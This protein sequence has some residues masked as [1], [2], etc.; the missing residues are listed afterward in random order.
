VEQEDWR[1][2]H[3]FHTKVICGGNICNVIVDNGSIE[4]IASKEDV[5]K[6]KLPLKNV[7]NHTKSHR[8]RRIMR[9]MG[10]FTRMKYGVISYQWM[11]VIFY[12]VV[13]IYLIVI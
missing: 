1:R 12:W 5:E 4:N 11:L 2:H 6:L 13:P 9:Y 10:M 7:P 3:I 8:S